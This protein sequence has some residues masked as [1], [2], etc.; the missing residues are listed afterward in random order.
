MSPEEVLPSVAGATITLAGF[1][2]VF[3]AFSRSTGGDGHS[4]IRLNSILELGIAAALLCFLPAVLQSFGLSVNRS[5]RALSAVGGIYYIHWLYEFWKVR[6][7][8]HQT[9][10]SYRVATIS[11]CAVFALFCANALGVTSNV[12]GIYLIAILLILFLQG[13]AF[14]SQFWAEQA[15]DAEI[16]DSTKD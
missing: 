10:R 7:A 3:R 12:D 9:P 8:D 13:L 6:N 4:N 11:A 5:Y 14:L 1:A 15:V 16:E 2:A